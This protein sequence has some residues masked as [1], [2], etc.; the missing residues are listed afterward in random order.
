M[1]ST[2]AVI[3][4]PE[5]PVTSADETIEE[6]EQPR[7]KRRDV[8]APEVGFFEFLTKFTRPQWESLMIYVYRLAPITDRL[9]G[10]HQNKFVVKYTEPIDEDKLKHEHGSGKYRLQLNELDNKGKSRTIRNVEVEIEDPKFPPNVPESE[11]VDD[12]RNKRWAWARK[13]KEEP[14]AAAPQNAQMSPI[15]TMRMVKDMAREMNS[16][17]NN[18]EAAAFPKVMDMLSKASDRSLDIATKQN[19]PDHLVKM[20]TAVKELTTPAKDSG[21]SDMV[22]ILITMQEGADRR[23]EAAEKRAEAAQERADK[24]LMKLMD[25]GK[26]QKSNIQETVTLMTTVMDFATKLKG[27]GDGGS[28]GG[29]KG[30]VAQSAEYIPAALQHVEGI[31]KTVMGAQVR[32]P[33]QTAAQGTATAANPAPAQVQAGQPV[34]VQQEEEPEVLDAAQKILRKFTPFV[35]IF[36]EHIAMSLSS[37]EHGYIFAERFISRFSRPVYDE[38][39]SLGKDKLIEML[40]T[41]DAAWFGQVEARLLPF[42]DQFLAFP[43]GEPAELR[44]EDEEPEPAP[45]PKRSKK[46]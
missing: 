27:D 23:A 7:A 38:I 40:K 34:E 1:A 43:Q 33:A 13:G 15:E 8:T 39:A 3:D 35:P 44:D 20:L 17:S 10:G 9:A 42:V 5:V 4:D 26:G 11:W 46:P 14:A 21:S 29:W 45:K 16:G 2:R 30:V 36:T 41:N 22:K 6:Q 32:R 18:A 12:P 19:D 28:L 24:L 37:E 25:D 31:V